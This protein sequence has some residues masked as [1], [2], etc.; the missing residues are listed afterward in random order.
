MIVHLRLPTVRNYKLQ[1]NFLM[2][3]YILWFSF[4]KNNFTVQYIQISQFSIHKLSPL[5]LVDAGYFLFVKL[6]DNRFL[7]FVLNLATTLS[8]FSFPSWD[9][10]GP[11]FV[12]IRSFQSCDL[13]FALCAVP[14][15]PSSALCSITTSICVLIIR[16]KDGT[17]RMGE[18][19][20]CTFGLIRLCIEYYVRPQ[21]I[22]M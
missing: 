21:G 4:I 6:S 10:A 2:M 17:L 1:K 15:V 14:P 16:E 3:S 5:K 18:G 8:K 20:K 9:Q 7:D 22:Y 11:S 19:Q 12:A 13:V